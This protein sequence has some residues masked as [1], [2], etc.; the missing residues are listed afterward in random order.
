L[1]KKRWSGEG[2]G[3]PQDAEDDDGGAVGDSLVLLPYK[4]KAIYPRGK[5]KETV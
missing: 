5:G 2:G 4:E 1:K 3:E